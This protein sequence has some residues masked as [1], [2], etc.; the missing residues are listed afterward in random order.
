[1][2]KERLRK[3]ESKFIVDEIPHPEDIREVE[4]L[5]KANTESGEHPPLRDI[6][7]KC[8]YSKQVIIQACKNLADEGWLK[9][10]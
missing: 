5:I 10:K 1:M 3:I 6:H 4:K 8:D 7:K 2:D 9:E